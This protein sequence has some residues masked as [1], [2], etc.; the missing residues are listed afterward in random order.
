MSWNRR[1]TLT[2]KPVSKK[3]RQKAAKEK[4]AKSRSENVEM[5]ILRNSKRSLKYLDAASSLDEYISFAYLCFAILISIGFLS[6]K[7]CY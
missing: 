1:A 6:L 5:L 7:T 2:A 4:I 3:D